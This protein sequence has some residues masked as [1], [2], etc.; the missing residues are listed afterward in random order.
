MKIKNEM[1]PMWNSLAQAFKINPMH[2]IFTYGD[3]IYNPSG[4]DLDARPDLIAHEEVHEKQQT[5]DGMTPELWWGKFLRDPKFR[6]EQEAAGYAAQYAFICNHPDK[7]HRASGREQ[8]FKVRWQLAGSLAGPLYNHC[9]GH[10]D[11]EALIKKL[12]GIKP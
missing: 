6:M 10:N 8:R 12:S 5:A 3:T 2:A 9:I 7:R 11:A 4:I 1:P